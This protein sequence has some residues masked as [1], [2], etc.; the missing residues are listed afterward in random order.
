MVHVRTALNDS[1]SYCGKCRWF[2]LLIDVATLIAASDSVFDW[3]TGRWSFDVHHFSRY[4]LLVD[5][6]DEDETMED[7]IDDG[8]VCRGQCC[9]VGHSLAGDDAIVLAQLWACR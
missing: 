1:T 4:G 5:D 9:L 8:A 7:S 6:S 2:H 3:D